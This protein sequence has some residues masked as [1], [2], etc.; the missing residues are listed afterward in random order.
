[1]ARIADKTVFQWY[2]INQ[3]ADAAGILYFI[4]AR[5]APYNKWS[6]AGCWAKIWAVRRC[7][8]AVHP[9]AAQGLQYN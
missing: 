8:Q 1:M 6:K 5:A 9:V 7:D 2:Y 4:T 3:T